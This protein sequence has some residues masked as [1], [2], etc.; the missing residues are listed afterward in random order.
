MGLAFLKPGFVEDSWGWLRMAE[1]RSRKPPEQARVILATKEM[2]QGTESGSTSP[3]T[4]LTG[5]IC[6]WYFH[7]KLTSW[8]L[9]TSLVVAVTLVVAV[10]DAVVVVAAAP[11]PELTIRWL[12]QVIGSHAQNCLYKQR[13]LPLSFPAPP[14]PLTPLIKTKRITATKIVRPLCVHQIP[15]MFRILPSRSSSSWPPSSSS[16]SP[17]SPS[18]P[19]FFSFR[20]ICSRFMFL[21]VSSCFVLFFRISSYFFVFL[22]ISSHFFEFLRVS[23]SFFLGFSCHSGSAGWS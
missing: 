21:L 6:G 1:D 5:G 20:L 17:T 3:H 16:T 12:R 14:C 13:T 4:S 18:S 8:K 15:N 10:L 2:L 19:Y 7:L 11:N 22:R 9:K 23:S